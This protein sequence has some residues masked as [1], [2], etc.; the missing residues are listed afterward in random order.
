M[1]TDGDDLKTVRKFKH[2]HPSRGLSVMMSRP[3]TK[4][5]SASELNTLLVIIPRFLK[6]YIM[7]IILRPVEIQWLHVEEAHELR[8]DH[9]SF[10]FFHTLQFLLYIF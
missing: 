1:G 2:R 9:P 6:T 5:I 10:T 4:V 8:S 3:E 7:Y